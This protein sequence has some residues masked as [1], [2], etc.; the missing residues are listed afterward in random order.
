LYAE[1]L[2][3]W[4]SQPYSAPYEKIA[5]Q[6]RYEYWSY[7]NH[8]AGEIK[9]RRVMCKGGRM[10]YGFGFWLFKFAGSSP[11]SGSIGALL[12]AGQRS[13]FEFSDATFTIVGAARVEVTVNDHGLTVTVRDPATL[14]LL[15]SGRPNIATFNVEIP[16]EAS[17]S[18][19]LSIVYEG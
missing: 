7:P 18:R 3:I 1:H 15:F 2:D 12:A 17:E 11:R 10:T 16:G 8:N 4:C 13:V 19:T 6:K 14:T 5:A 9:D